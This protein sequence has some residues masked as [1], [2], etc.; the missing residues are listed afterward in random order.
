MRMRKLK[1]MLLTGMLLCMQFLWAQ[2]QVTG[3]VTDAKDG[4]PLAGVTVSVKNAT[5]STVTGPDG[6]FSLNAPA[7]STLV[8]SYIGYQNV[9]KSATASPLTIALTPGENALTEVV[10]VGYGTKI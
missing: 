9:E 8:F 7:K 4:N 2:T 10:V 6:T 3:K 5:T 1:A